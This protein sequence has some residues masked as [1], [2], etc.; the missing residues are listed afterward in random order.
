MKSKEK[1]TIYQQAQRFAD[2]TKKC[3]MTGNVRRAKHCMQ[4]AE[5][6]FTN[7]SKEIQ[8]AIS[9]VYVYS[10][11]S[12]MELRHCSIRAFFSQKLQNEYYKQVNTSGL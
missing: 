6:M 12:F 2:I 9:N 5:N 4:V 10:L 1:Q 7:G 8:N 11:S 3:L